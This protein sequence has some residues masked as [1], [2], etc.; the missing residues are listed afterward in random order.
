MFRCQLLCVYERQSRKRSKDEDVTHDSDAFQWKVFV[1]DSEQFIHSQELAYNFLLVEFDADKRIF[2]NP[3]IGQCKIG[4]FL[5][6]F[7][8]TDNGV[9]LA[10]FFCFEVELKGT[11]QLTVDFRQR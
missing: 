4:D 7:H 3:F 9:L 10:G 8:V 2:G 11:N 1:V 5:Q 6:A